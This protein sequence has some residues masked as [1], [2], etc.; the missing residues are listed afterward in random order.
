MLG[1]NHDICNVKEEG[2]IWF[3]VSEVAVAGELTVRQKPQAERQGRTNLLA[4][5]KQRGERER[6]KGPETRYPLLRQAPRDC[7]LQLGL[8]SEPSIQLVNL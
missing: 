2:L 6:R 1:Q 3:I 4:C 5:E 8:T 7:F